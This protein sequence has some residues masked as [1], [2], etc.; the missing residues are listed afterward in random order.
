MVRWRDVSHSRMAYQDSPAHP[1][2]GVTLPDAEA[3]GYSWCKAP[4]LDGEVV[5]VGALA[6]QLLDGQPLLTD[7]VTRDGGNVHS[8]VVARLVEVARVT[9]AMEAWVA[10]LRPGEPFC[11]HAA[12]PAEAE[13]CGLVEG[14][15][16]SLGH[17]LRIRN[18]RIL[19]YQ[20][21]APTTRNFS[22]RDASGRPGALEAA[23]VGTPVRPGETE[24]VAVQHVV[25]SFDPCMVCTVH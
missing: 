5:E 19:N 8:R 11:D 2:Q 22:P 12:L 21:V 23:L 13:G 16:G 20:I 10:E 15:R 7:L 14:A 25:R 3:P 4:R 17:W 18:G 24:P 9:M 1:Y 6:R